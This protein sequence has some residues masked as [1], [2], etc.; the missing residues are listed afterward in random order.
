MTEDE[1]STYG[2]VP[3]LVQ[4]YVGQLREIAGGWRASPDLAEVSRGPL[5][6]FRCLAA[7]RRR[8]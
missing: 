1:H 6:Y 3:R 4:E 7:F 2:M 8:R 5:A